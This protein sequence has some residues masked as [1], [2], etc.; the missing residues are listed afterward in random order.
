MAFAVAGPS[1]LIHAL[2]REGQ[3]VERFLLRSWGPKKVSVTSVKGRLF[4]ISACWAHWLDAMHGRAGAQCYNDPTLGA[5]ELTWAKR[6]HP[7]RFA[8]TGGRCESGEAWGC[9]RQVKG[10]TRHG[11]GHTKLSPHT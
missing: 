1:F 11:P 6:C 10:Q 3:A 2:G 4:K 7:L 8:S 9:T 5:Q